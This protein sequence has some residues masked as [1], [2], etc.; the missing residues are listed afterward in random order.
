MIRM[1]TTRKGI[2]IIYGARRTGK[3]I[4]LDLLNKFYDLTDWEIE[5]LFTGTSTE[6]F[7]KL[8]LPSICRRFCVR[9]FKNKPSIIKSLDINKEWLNG[10]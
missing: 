4:A 1:F 10:K 6:T 3:S 2:T 7:I 5:K 8:Y 9:Y